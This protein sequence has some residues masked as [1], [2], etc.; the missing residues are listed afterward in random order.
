MTITNISVESGDNIVDNA[1]SRE[2]DLAMEVEKR[3]IAELVESAMSADYT[4]V[5]R[6][7][8][9]IARDLASQGDVASS[10]GMPFYVAR[11]DSL[12]SSRLEET[13]KN[14]RGVFEYVPARKA[15][16][17]LDEMDS[18]A[19]VRDD[20]HEVGEVKRVFN[21]VLQGLDALTDDV[22]IVAATNHPHLLDPAIWRRFPYEV[23]ISLPDIDVRERM[24]LHFLYDGD[25]K[26]NKE[27]RILMAVSEGLSGSDIENVALAARRREI[28]SKTDIDL[29]KIILAMAGSRPSKTRLAEK[30]DFDISDMKALTEFP[31]DAKDISQ[32]NITRTVGITRQSVSKHLKEI[33][34]G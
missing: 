13:A 10:L 17:F 23:K 21:T 33:K 14:I 27:A 34:D 4:G 25:R 22:I 7:G 18:I 6:V 8:G 28:F 16:L 32:A 19:K 15:V 9:A 29:S 24:W 2:D 5:R 31:Y 1:G 30:V 11:L 3:V 12:I 20:R 26:R